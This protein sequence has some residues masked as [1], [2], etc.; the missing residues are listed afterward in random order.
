MS[1]SQ[2]ASM[3][4]ESGGAHLSESSCIESMT[5]KHSPLRSPRG[6]RRRSLQ[7]NKDNKNDNKNKDKVPET[8]TPSR[9]PTS[10][11][12]RLPTSIPSQLPTPAPS[13]FPTSTPTLIPDATTSA[14][15]R[16][17]VVEIEPTFLSFQ[18]SIG[19]K[20]SQHILQADNQ[21]SSFQTT[22][23]TDWIGQ[24][25][26]CGQG[27]TILFT[28]SLD[29]ESDCEKGLGNS[30]SDQTM[31][32][33]WNAPT[34][35]ARVETLEGSG[36]EY[37]FWLVTFPV[38]AEFYDELEQT[39][40][41]E[42]DI[43]IAEEELFLPWDSGLLSVVGEEEKFFSSLNNTS[44]VGDDTF[45]SGFA[46]QPPTPLYQHK[47]H[48]NLNR[49][50]VS[51]STASK[52]LQGIGGISAILHTICLIGLHRF[53]KSYLIKKKEREI[54]QT[55][56]TKPTIERGRSRTTKKST[57]II[58]S[59]EYQSEDQGP[60]S[61]ATS[62]GDIGLELLLMATNKESINRRNSSKE[63]PSPNRTL[64]SQRMRTPS[65]PN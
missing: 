33:V 53:G 35:I 19:L 50:A 63:H 21:S 32:I 59:V 39:L 10:I 40:Q 49:V 18:G 29:L 23:L 4:I 46:T 16:S 45:D 17:P 47:T 60:S 51:E 48:N 26:L 54:P 36:I 41:K 44:V 38:Y 43:Q 12:S 15:S 62:D 6:R 20:W 11:P 9:L 56:E 2:F 57:S 24:E 13:R 31:T 37:S 14:P 65:P 25:F 34:A 61:P 22:D 28:S 7:N 55:E 30:T 64:Y 1:L 5:K 52:V 58:S 27:N 42:L 3:T 8:A